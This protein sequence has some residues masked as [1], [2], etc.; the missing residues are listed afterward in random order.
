M[1]RAE[2]AAADGSTTDAAAISAHLRRTVAAMAEVADTG[3]G[4]VARCDELPLVHT[5][6]QVHVTSAAAP[7][8][9]VAA[10]ASHQVHL[11]YRHLVVEEPGTAAALRDALAGEEGW[12]LDREVRMS[13]V[14]P[15]ARGVDTS[16]V[17]ELTEA[18]TVALM[19][20][21]LAE[22][23]FD[24]APGVVDELVEYQR[25]EGLAWTERRFGVRDGD[26]APVA[27]T[28]L[29]TDGKGTAWV[30]DVYALPSARGS[31]NGRALV[32]RAADCARA[33]G[34]R[35]TF[36][37]AD[38]EDWPKHLYHE[39][40]FRPVAHAWTFHHEVATT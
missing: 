32:T 36:I 34:N 21:W 7:D 25:R 1:G 14:A 22:E 26:G 12:K 4:W 27:A 10:A 15:A 24:R 19:R 30:E 11:G 23:G 29:R 8:L 39:V 3:V 6:N 16:R 37:V 2:G 13:L 9:L 35:L 20:A 18:E 40:G 28:K 38:D 5:L 17:T 33:A 31:G